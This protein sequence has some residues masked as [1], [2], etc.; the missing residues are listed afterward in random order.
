MTFAV[1]ATS[2]LL[3]TVVVVIE[4]GP[5]L[6]PA[7]MVHLGWLPCGAGAVKHRFRRSR[8]TTS[9]DTALA[10]KNLW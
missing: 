2:A 3:G 5:T 7:T 4:R 9:E 10:G 1:L 6:D 8:E